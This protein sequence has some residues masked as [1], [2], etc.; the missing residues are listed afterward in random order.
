MLR[1]IKHVEESSSDEREEQNQRHARSGS[2][3]V[4]QLADIAAMHHS[5]VAS[6]AGGGAGDDGLLGDGEGAS[7]LE[8]GRI[9]RGDGDE[10]D[11]AGRGMDKGAGGSAEEAGEEDNF[12]RDL[13]D[14]DSDETSDEKGY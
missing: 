2:Y 9:P 5:S 6:A 14:D 1:C 11:G 4:D 10:E 12:A 13:D 7:A 3:A 8:A